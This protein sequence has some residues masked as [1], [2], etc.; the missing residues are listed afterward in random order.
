MR[1][2]LSIAAV[3]TAWTAAA[4]GTLQTAIRGYTNE[5]PAQVY[6]T[7]GGTFQTG[8]I[9]VTELGCFDYVFAQNAG[10]V[11]EVGLWDAN[12]TLLASS[13]ITPTSPLVDQA[14]YESITPVYLDP[15]K[16]YHL[17]A[18]S[19]N[20]SISLSIA[21]PSLG[22]V[23]D[24]APEITLVAAASSTGF[25]SPAEIPNTS[26]AFY[27][28]ANFRFE[29]RVPEPSSLLLLGLGGL[30]LLTR[31]KWGSSPNLSPCHPKPARTLS[32]RRAS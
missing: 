5:I 17:G 12:G 31:Q 23:I 27:L 32:R 16:L 2:L 15:G 22:G 19:P 11:I 9:T 30:F 28:G 14:R 20:G 6:G 1:L 13:T 10:S 3:A 21:A 4:Q 24:T 18:Y 7:A 29:D 8:F 25:S 26:G